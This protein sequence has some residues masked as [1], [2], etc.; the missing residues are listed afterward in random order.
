MRHIRTCPHDF[1]LRGDL[2]QL[3]GYKV[4]RSSRCIGFINV[5]IVGVRY[6]PCDTDTDPVSIL[7][8][9]RP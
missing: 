9:D 4:Q 6:I 8:N 2:Q 3:L 7:D 1:M 5:P